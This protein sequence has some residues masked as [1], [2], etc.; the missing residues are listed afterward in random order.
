MTNYL[1][2]PQ[3]LERRP[4][5]EISRRQRKQFKWAI[6]LLIGLLAV[7]VVVLLVTP[8]FVTR[9]VVE[10]SVENTLPIAVIKCAGPLS[11]MRCDV[12]DG[13][14]T[15]GTFLVRVKGSCW[16]ATEASGTELETRS[17]ASACL[18]V[19][20]WENVF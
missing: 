4:Q 3:T 18:R 8:G 15:P 6:G 7:S 12:Q 19:H 2:M 5:G 1:D 14:G 11:A 13:S 9:K 10:R 17:S 16:Q 20:L